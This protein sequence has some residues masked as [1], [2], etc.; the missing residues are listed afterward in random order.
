[1]A[2]ATAT[3]TTWWLVSGGR[4]WTR[5]WT[6]PIRTESSSLEWGRALPVREEREEAG[7]RLLAPLCRRDAKPSPAAR[8]NNWS[9]AANAVEVVVFFSWANAV[10]RWKWWCASRSRAKQK[11]N[12]GLDHR[13]TALKRGL[14]NRSICCFA[15]TLSSST[16]T[17]KFSW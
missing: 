1:M 6:P 14:R 17:K 7:G 12:S 5:G 4:G 13:L 10:E 8:R 16:G 11:R 15:R 3:A 2:V 9:A